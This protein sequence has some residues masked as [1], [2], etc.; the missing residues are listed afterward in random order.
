MCCTAPQTRR[1]RMQA[2][3][4][5][6]TLPVPPV[7]IRINLWYQDAVSRGTL[8][9]DW[10]GDTVA[11]IEDRLGFCRSARWRARPR[12]VFPG[13]TVKESDQGDQ[14]ITRYD[15][16]GA[17][18]KKVEQKTVEQAR[19][20]MRGTTVRYPVNDKAS[21][22][23]LLKAMENAWLEADLAGLADFDREVG[24]AGL[25]LL[26]L[27]SCPAH[28]LMLDWFGYQNFFYALADYP[29]ILIEL[30]AA[31]ETIYRR[32]LW[33]PA[34]RTPAELIMHGNHLADATTP[35][36]LFRRFFLPY[37]Q[38]FNAR[39]HEAGKKALWHA[40]AQM[41]TLLE[42]V[43]EAGF[44]G[45]DCLATAPLV[46]QTMADYD[47]V[48]QNRIVKWGGLPGTLFNPEIPETEFL[49]HVE[50]LQSFTRDRSGFI[51]GASDNVMP[52]ACWKRIKMLSDA[53]PFESEA[54]N[55]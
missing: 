2:V 24:D 7:S 1:Q 18:L 40:D 36:P 14:H 51:I 38:H 33:E 32:D 44:D 22:S 4:S 16:P 5:G 11:D 9:K 42:L 28:A 37:F 34:L 48:W 26:I 23:A 39:V 20:G 41:G 13:N 46:K 54:L 21:C 43:L 31:F 45:A 53:F 8:P 17:A 27:G 55:F 30:I 25:P 6:A 10:S 12:L 3:F 47:Q 50:A 49:K 19:A 15:F 52:G 29:E 35:P